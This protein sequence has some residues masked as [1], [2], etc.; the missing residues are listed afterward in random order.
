MRWLG[1]HTLDFDVGRFTNKFIS[2]LGAQ[3]SLHSWKVVTLT[4][5]RETLA[6]LFSVQ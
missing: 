3:A 2:G 1:A 5:G 4:T 6:S